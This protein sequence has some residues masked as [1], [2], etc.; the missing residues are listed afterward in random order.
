[1][2]LR[3]LNANLNTVRGLG[4]AAQRSLS[5]LE[6]TDIRGLLCHYPRDWADRSQPVSLKDWSRARVCTTVTVLAHEWFGAGYMK[7]LK[8]YVEDDTARAS[9][10]CFNR[11]FLGKQLPVGLTVRLYGQFFY[12]Y[13]EIQSSA[14]EIAGE[15]DGSFGRILP[16]YPLS[17]GLTQSTLRRFTERALAQYAPSLEDELPGFITERDNLL[18]KKDA[19]R[20][21]HFPSS[22][23][24]RDRARRT[25]IYEELFY[26]EIMTLQNRLLRRSS[27]GMAAGNRQPATYNSGGAGQS[28]QLNLLQKRLIERLPFNL[29]P[30][31]LSVVREINADMDGPYPM[32]RLL[33]G[34]VGSG[35]TL[36]AFLACLKAIGDS[37]G[38]AALMAPTELLARQHAETAARF[39]EP[40]GVRIAFLTGNV[41]AGGRSRLLAALAAGEID[42]VAGTHA[43]FSRDTVY[44]NL[45]LVVVDEQHRFGVTQRQAIMDKGNNPG[46]LMMS[47]TP[48]PRTLA[49]T[50]FGD[51]DVSV[52]SDM[53]P[54]RK[55]VKTHLAK[56][57]NAD[58]VYDFVRKELAAGHQAYF[59][60]PIIDTAGSEPRESSAA[61][62]KDLKDAQSMAEKL[63]R[64]TFPQYKAALIHSRLDE[65]EKQ[66]TMDEFRKGTI[67][68]LA[69]TSVVEVGVDVPN[70]T[71]MVVE[72]A[73]RFGLAAL[74]QLR[75]RVGRSD[76]QSYCFLIYSDQDVPAEYSGMDP[77]LLGEEDRSREG[78]RLMVMLE[79]NDG[80]VIAEKDLQF[81]GPGQITGLQQSGYL[82]LGI[83]DP[84]RD[85]AELEKARDDAFK[86]LE[87]DPG[88]L[89]EEN[90]NIGEVLKRAPPF[91]E[92]AM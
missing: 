87:K 21:I 10:I 44:R 16:I 34:D 43:L 55:P 62:K 46:L 78:R 69:A 31:Q 53:P 86:I 14:F 8:I 11:P 22:F 15:K 54:G 49:L 77:Q 45:K 29:T 5:R 25:L 72:H 2:F 9:L 35:K 61:W 73:E 57:S 51:L 79:N 24:E 58:K 28:P 20:E 68:V 64:E 56:I 17:E 47:A 75:G 80:F 89:K 13:G 70:A 36:A 81:R 84:V 42:L 41:K 32:A 4:P 83:A 88:F 26:L 60:Y 40:L 18:S 39:L 74:H 12:K 63:S 3:E 65:E 91:G 85:A 1:M 67:K 38:Q 19:I 30:G 48:I 59:V 92:V 7:T 50:V 27:A 23:T 66:R 6:I 82:A 71:C 33:Q 52:I 90:R 76:V 37:G